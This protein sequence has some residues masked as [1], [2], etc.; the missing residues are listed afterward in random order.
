MLKIPYVSQPDSKSCALASYAMVAKYFFPEVS[1][2]DIARISE[3]KEGYVVWAYK[4]WLWIM[5]KGVKIEEYD[6]VDAKAWAHEGLEGLRKSVSEKEFNYYIEN[7]KDIESY[8]EDIKKVLSHPNFIFHKQ[9]PTLELLE[10]KLLEGN[11]CEVVLDSRTLRNKEGFSLHRV[12]ILGI[13]NG[14]VFFHDPAHED[15][16][17]I[18]I[19]KFKSSDRKSVV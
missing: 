5:D 7:T 1:L 2:Q 8:S 15:K 18:S 11:I 10:N 4:F 3:W 14:N 12:V 13:E 17:N 9:K 19:E 6:L 16:G